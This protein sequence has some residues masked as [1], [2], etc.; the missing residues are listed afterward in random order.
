MLGTTQGLVVG[1]CFVVALGCA[2]RS[3]PEEAAVV[4]SAAAAAS[5]TAPTETVVQ[6]THARARRKTPCT[7]ILA[8]ME[9]VSK[10]L[11]MAVKTTPGSWGQVPKE[12][13]VLPPGA[14]HCGSVDMMDQAIIASPLAGKEM[15]AF[16]TPL[17]P[18]LAV[19]R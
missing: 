2:K 8:Q 13:Q 14:Q 3:T 10:D 9:K 19:S 18:K 12:L 6:P 17:S 16:Y 15:E 4:T 11:K 7:E 1:V 5:A